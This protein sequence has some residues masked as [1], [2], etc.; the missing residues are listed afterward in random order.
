MEAI[1]PQVSD[2]FSRD[3]RFTRWLQVEAALANAQGALGI[4]PAQAARDISEAAHVEK[5]ALDRYDE[6]YAKTGHPMVSMLRLL[7]AAA[8]PES[9]QYIHLG[10]TTQDIMDSAMTLALRSMFTLT[11]AKL[12]S[13]QS[14]VLDLCQRH[15]DTPMMGRTHNIQALPITFGYKAAIWADELERC[16]DRLDQSAQRILA[17]QLSGAVGSMVSFGED[18][19][20]IQE[21][22]AE[23]LGL[24]VPAVSWHASRDRLAE[25]TGEL[26]L[27]GGCL[28]R[29]AQ[30]VYLLMGSETA[31]LSEPWAAGKV[32]SST[33]PHKVN[34]TSTQHMMSLARDIRYHHAA[35]LEMMWV[36]HER[37]IMHFVGERQHIEACCVAAGELMD[38]ADALMAGLQVNEA[39][40]RANLNRL[41]GLT[42]SEHVMLEL[43][44]RIGKQHAHELINQIAV[45]AF[46]NGKNFEEEL[47]KN[48]TVVQALGAEQIHALLDPMQ[49]L[50]KCPELARRAVQTLRK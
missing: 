46:Q 11:R 37:N 22:M 12:V 19:D 9:G 6:F 28:G 43:G 2:L 38:R 35:V 17:L 36:D 41:G 47:K 50:G 32:G 25:F 31:E 20:A 40:M 4:I 16:I 13:I 27:I 44:K 23:Q 42:Q 49:Y 34:P 33:M 8:G 39:N 15:A 7:E 26:A 29:I 14:S 18:G 45:D 10:A 48:D 30:E 24:S 21:K 3:G 5:L 1:L